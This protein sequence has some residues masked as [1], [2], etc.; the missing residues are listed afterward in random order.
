PAMSPNSFQPLIEAV[1]HRMRWFIPLLLAIAALKR[2]FSARLK[3]AAGERAVARVLNRLG[4]AALHDIILPDGRG[5][6]TQIDHLV[7]TPAGLGLLVVETKNYS[8]QVLGQPQD[9]KW[10]QRLGRQS[11]A[12]LNPL[13]QNYLHLQALKALVPTVPLQGRVVFTDAAR[14]PKGIPEGVSTLSTLKNDLKTW[15]K[16]RAD[17]SALQ[18]AWIQINAAARTDRDSRKAH[19]AALHAKHGRDWRRSFAWGLLAVAGIWLA[20]LLLLDSQKIG[21][22]LF[23]TQAGQAGQEH[24]VVR[25]LR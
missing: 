16:D 10:T 6:L 20:V 1:I 24:A 13:R 21:L 11:F 12:F 8:G 19:L 4:E 25:P 15:L 7:L 9:S 22:S 2:L 14:F 3:G 5:G 18:S 23:D 17:G